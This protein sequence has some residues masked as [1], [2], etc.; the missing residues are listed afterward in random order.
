M[1]RRPSLAAALSALFVSTALL[2]GGHAADLQQLR[3][4]TEITGRPTSSTPVRLPL[5]Q[6]V[7]AETSKGFSDLRLFDDQGVETPYVI[8]PEYK[9][10]QTSQTFAFAIIAYQAGQAGQ[11]R[12]NG[13]EIVLEQ[14]RQNGKKGTQTFRELEFV[15]P[16]RNFIKSVRIQTREDAAT[17]WQDLT[18]DTIFDFSSR[19]DLRKTSISIPETNA[20]YVRVLLQDATQPASGGPD[21]SLRYDGL[22]FSVAGEQASP[23]RID[24]ILGR[25]GT[26]QAARRFYNQTSFPNLQTTIDTDGNTRIDL[27]R[28]NLP[29]AEIAFKIDNAYYY[30]QV[31]V[32]AAEDG[33]NENNENDEESK[34]DAYQRMASGVIYTIPWQE[35]PERIISVNRSLQPY[36]LIKILNGD[37]P[38]LRISQV[39]VSW[40]RHNLYFIPEAER[41]YELY[42]GGEQLRVPDYE[43][44]K[45]LRADYAT[46]Q[47]Y[48]AWSAGQAQA[49]TDYEPSLSGDTQAQMEKIV[50][51]AFVLLL[52]CGLG[53]WGYQLLKKMPA[54]SG[55]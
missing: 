44:G 54:Q 17:N 45:L 43:L 13:E 27:G 31:E 5:P 20:S 24:K 48:P 15:T 32:W 50:F 34:E 18:T 16:G 41:R 40:V 22:E 23:F 3:F 53:W 39:D 30:R 35:K 46:L 25:A 10:S 12:D 14:P 6:A 42:F 55:E 11:A 21:M 2:A 8:Y 28:V 1:R 33:E 7:V 52:A 47:A 9:A 37:N 51:S 26:A 36:V 19:V 29:L 49:N 38:P 4:W